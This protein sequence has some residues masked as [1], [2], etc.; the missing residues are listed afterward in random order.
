MHI[1]IE[2][3]FKCNVD[4]IHCDILHRFIDE[5][6]ARIENLEAKVV[7]LTEAVDIWRKAKYEADH[8]QFHARADRKKA[9][10]K[11]KALETALKD[12]DPNHPLL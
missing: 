6:A 9:E 12:L 7:D 3:I 1:E 10:D 5:Q 8:R 2:T 4:H 11:M